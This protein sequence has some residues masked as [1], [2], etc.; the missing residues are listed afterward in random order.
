MKQIIFKQTNYQIIFKQQ[1]I[2]E[3]VIS[4]SRIRKQI[5]MRAMLIDN[6]QKKKTKRN[7]KKLEETN[8]NYPKENT[9]C[10]T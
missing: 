1:I 6:L 7:E 10:N 3:L 5:T 2:K 9:S 4:S 8:D